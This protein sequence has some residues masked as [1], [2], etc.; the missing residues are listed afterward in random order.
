MHGSE[1]A[2]LRRMSGM[3]QADVAE[4]LGVATRTVISWERNGSPSEAAVEL[5]R[6]GA[7]YSMELAAQVADNAE[8][9]GDVA[10][11]RLVDGVDLTDRPE[12]A[13]MAAAILWYRGYVLDIRE[14]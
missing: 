8:K 13:G 6:D 9:Q 12:V 7:A 4:K 2:L 14:R 11:L 5:V 10:I 3:T 1:F